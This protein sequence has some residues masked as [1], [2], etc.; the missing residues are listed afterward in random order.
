MAEKKAETKPAVADVATKAGDR[1][2][3]EDQIHGASTGVALQNFGGQ[4]LIAKDELTTA[5]TAVVVPD[6]ELTIVK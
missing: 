5:K 2:S 4:V 3:W 6:D 1:V